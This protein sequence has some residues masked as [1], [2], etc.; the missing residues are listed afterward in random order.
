MNFISEQHEMMGPKSSKLFTVI[1]PALNEEKVIGK[2]LEA[3]DGMNFSR[4]SMEVI[5]VDNGSVDR[6]ISIARGFEQKL[7][8]RVLEKKSVHI[9]AMRNAGAAEAR[10]E[11]LAFLDADCIVRPDWLANATQLLT[12]PKAGV[13]GAHYEIPADAT[14]V[15]R[16]WYQDRMAEKVGNVRYIPAGDMFLRKESFLAVGGF[17]ETIQTNEDFELCQ[18]VFAYGLPVRSYPELRVVHLGTPRT[19][20]SFYRKQRWHGI[21]VLTVFL[22]EI[23]KGRNLLPVLFAVFTLVCLSGIVVA[24]IAAILG[25]TWKIMG[26]FLTA[27]FL[28]ILAIALRRCGKKG[29]WRDVLPVAFLYLTF[30]VARAICLLD[31]KAWTSPWRTRKKQAAT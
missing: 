17:D 15:G 30:G 21:H 16:T 9:S 11:I 20:A 29:Q 28:P 10:G 13:G 12:D 22:R 19:L 1:I 6:T 8:L 18:R 3:L 24:V 5:L 4:E 26:L 23:S 7:N 25:A 27:L 14:W 31:L 2:C